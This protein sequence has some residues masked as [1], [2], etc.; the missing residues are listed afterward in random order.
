MIIELVFETMLCNKPLRTPSLVR[1]NFYHQICLFLS[2]LEDVR[3]I[4]L[5]FV[6]GISTVL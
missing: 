1:H 2:L 6:T 3:F 4:G 5:V